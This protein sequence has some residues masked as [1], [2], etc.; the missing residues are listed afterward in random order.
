MTKHYINAR[1]GSDSYPIVVG[2]GAVEELE[3]FL[4]GADKPVV[5]V[6]DKYFRDDQ[7]SGSILESIL[8]T[9]PA[10]FLDGGIDSKGIDSAMHII[11]WLFSMNF[12]RDGI[13]VAI[14]GGVIGDLGAFVASVFM[15]GVSLVHVPT[16]TTS[17]IDSS[18]GGK[19]GVN[20]LGQVNLM[21]TYYNPVA[22]FMDLGFI[23]TLEDRDYAAGLCESVK[24]ALTSDARMSNRLLGLADS[25]L[26]R[27]KSSVLEI[28]RWSV[29]TK[30]AH[31][32]EDF[33]E[34]S[35]RLLLNYGHTFGQSIESFYGLSHEALR[36][37]EA[38]A[39]GM[40]AAARLADLLASTP[41]DDRRG[42]ESFTISLLDAFG[43]PS[44]LH[45]LSAGTLPGLSTLVEGLVHD[46]KR[47]SSGNRFVLL[48]RVGSARVQQIDDLMLLR[49]AYSALL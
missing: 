37:G 5:L 17:M 41:A 26:K 10:T 29:T 46:K 25:L 36:H 40:V 20:H 34:K 42:L 16:T 43:L 35:L 3:V 27:E 15:R 49:A 39:L 22:T 13:L 47:V 6:V 45:H 28:V 4:E 18:I 7:V 32:A 14:G 31:V 30:L 9:Y 23:D 1:V 8:G 33:R 12:P 19:T 21:G 2:C 48:D 38:V 44:S 11:D 24:M